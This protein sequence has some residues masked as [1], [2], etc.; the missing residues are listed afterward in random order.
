MTR[1]SALTFIVLALLAAPVAAEQ[2]VPDNP[3]RQ[4]DIERVVVE[5]ARR[6]AADAVLMQVQTPPRPPAP[7]PLTQAPALP[8]LRRRGSMVGY[9]DDAVIG[10]KLRLRYETAAENDVPDRA[11][12][13]YAK[14]GCY[15]DLDIDDPATIPRSPG[16]RP[17]AASDLDFQQVF[18]QG[19]VEAGARIS[20]F[21]ELPLRWI[22]LQEFIPGT[23]GPFEDKGGIGDLRGGIKVALASER[24][25]GR[26]AAAQGVL[27]DR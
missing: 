21:A 25:P 4:P 23:G 22:A 8:S 2:A 12:F 13:F 3:G 20:F 5:L 10:T 9:L 17:G 27:P 7:P 18:L 6:D 16:P 26:H 15:R 19:E 11:E 14:C 24:Q 1:V